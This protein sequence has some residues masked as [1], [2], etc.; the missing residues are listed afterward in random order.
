MT[1]LNYREKVTVIMAKFPNASKKELGRQLRKANPSIF[2]T[3]EAARFCI[4]EFTGAAGAKHRKEMKETLF[5]SE[6]LA[7]KYGIPSEIPE[8]YVPYVIAPEKLLVISDVHIPFHNTEALV[9]ALEYGK[10][11]GCESILLNGDIMDCHKVSHFRNVAPVRL[12]FADEVRMARMFLQ[13]LVKQFKHVWYKYGNHEERY[14]NYLMDRAADLYG[15]EQFELSH[16]LG[17]YDLG[18]KWIKD[19][20]PVQFDRLTILHGHE[21]KGGIIAPVN[22]ARGLFLRAKSIAMMGHSHQTSEHT[23]TT[24]DD[25][26]LTCWS[27]GCLAQLHPK[28]MPLNKFN[29]GFAVVD[30]NARGGFRVENKRILKGNVL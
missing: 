15:V 25:H 21:H 9:C 2:K 26:I 27:V 10:A 7:K 4:R 13:G 5:S 3:D 20:R 18:I 30:K 16:I 24:L 1:A 29:H 22:A 11:H 12:R 28:Y 14:E 8:D 17:L 19:M 23:E 6:A